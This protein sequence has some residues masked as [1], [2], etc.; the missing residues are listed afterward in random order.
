MDAQTLWDCTMAFSIAEHLRAHPEVYFLSPSVI[1]ARC[2]YILSPLPRWV[3][4]TGEHNPLR[5][6]PNVLLDYRMCRVECGD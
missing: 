5:Y 3:P 4:T 2:G 6:P 1:G